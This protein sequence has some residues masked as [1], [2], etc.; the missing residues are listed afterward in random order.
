MSKPRL[1]HVPEPQLEFRFGQTVDYPRDGLYL[2]GPVDAARE[3]RQV[4]YGV[5]GTPTSLRR[6]KEWASQVSS[7]IDVP[8][9]RRRSTNTPRTF[10]GSSKHVYSTIKSS[11]RLYAKR[12]LRR[13]N[14]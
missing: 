7:F 1:I 4:R 11:R 6:F 12:R 14:S 9:P 2:F 3:P 5:I 10:V 8:P 13:T